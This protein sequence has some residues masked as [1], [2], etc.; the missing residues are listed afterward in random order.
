M[1]S[2]PWPCYRRISLRPNS[3]FFRPNFPWNWKLF[4]KTKWC[5]CSKNFWRRRRKNS[6]WSTSRW[7][8]GMSQI[9]RALSTTHYLRVSFMRKKANSGLWDNMLRVYFN[10]CPIRKLYFIIG[11]C[12]FLI[13]WTRLKSLL[14]PNNSKSVIW[15]PS[16]LP[17]YVLWLWYVW[18]GF[19]Q[20]FFQ[21][22]FCSDFFF[23]SHFFEITFEINHWFYYVINLT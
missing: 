11:K 10:I 15:K 20:T 21:K 14:M 9:E 7:N 23:K 22:S 19:S 18:N 12:C 4:R 6:T 8:I 2:I 3:T 5:S 1:T 17:L 16:F 13:G